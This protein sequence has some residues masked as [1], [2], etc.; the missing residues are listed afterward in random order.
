MKKSLLSALFLSAVVAY[1]Q[2]DSTNNFKRYGLGFFPDKKPKTIYGLS[3]GLFSIPDQKHV[4]NGLT[5]ELPGVGLLAGFGRG[6]D[7]SALL[8]A[9]KANG[10]I[11]SGTGGMMNTNGVYAGGFGFFAYKM[12]GIAF[13]MGICQVKYGNGI[14]IS[15]FNFCENVRGIQFGAFATAANVKGIQISIENRTKKLKGIQIGVWNV[16]EKRK[17][18]FINWNFSD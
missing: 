6:P 2:H 14:I 8:A 15:G 9:N 12:N 10:I 7:D 17:L 11:I 16:N 5:L 1:G 3:I 13:T 4:Y 18:P